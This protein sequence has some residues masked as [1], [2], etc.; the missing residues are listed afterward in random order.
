MKRNIIIIL[1]VLLISACSA[2][3][4]VET[5]H[6]PE[7][8][9]NPSLK[10]PE[11]LYFSAIGT[12]DTKQSA[13]Q[14]AYANIAKIFQ[15]DVYAKQVLSQTYQERI[16]E[17]DIEFSSDEQLENIYNFTTNQTLKN[18]KIGESFFDAHTG[19]HYVLAYLDRLDTATLYE[20]EI[21]RN[22]AQIAEFYE[23]YQV[24]DNKLEKLQYLRE[25]AHLT[26]MTELLNS[27]LRV[28]SPFNQ[29]IDLIFTSSALRNE[30]ERVA[31][32]VSVIIKTSGDYREQIE[33]YLKE[34]ITDF[35]FTVIPSGSIDKPDLEV[36]AHFSV[37]EVDLD[38]DE[39]FVRWELS[40]TILDRLREGETFTYTDSGREGHINL[41]Q[42]Q[43]RALRTA[44]E[45]I[46]T[47]FYEFLKR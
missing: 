27:Q 7:W 43:N 34:A 11:T 38:R 14:N 42:A 3:K 45:K 36:V 8:V 35:G 39:H 19:I 30:Q 47:D 1:T 40:I 10:Y 23:L 12:G 32:S 41:S 25:A 9:N 13:E 20:E 22:N 18:V 46:R 17:G 31:K 37:N 33:G 4:N 16:S 24:S 6:P 21:K 28:I 26:E 2:G 29:G 44:Q 15:V 5:P